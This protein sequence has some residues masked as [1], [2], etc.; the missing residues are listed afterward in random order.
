[1]E[2]VSK[3]RQQRQVLSKEQVLPTA[4]VLKSI[5]FFFNLSHLLLENHISITDL[6]IFEVMICHSQNHEE[7]LD[8]QR[9]SRRK[10][11]SLKQ[12]QIPQC[13]KVCKNVSITFSCLM[14]KITSNF[15]CVADQIFEFLRQKWAKQHILLICNIVQMSLF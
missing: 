9:N 15:T 8:F 4:A 2:E 6:L 13:L 3:T 5:I 14:A 11:I 7:T 12:P 10:K 1:M